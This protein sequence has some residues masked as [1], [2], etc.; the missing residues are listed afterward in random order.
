[1]RRNLLSTVKSGSRRRALSYE[2][3]AQIR[4]DHL[5]PCMTAHFKE[6]LLIE[7]GEGQY[8]YDHT[9]KKYLDLFAGI[10]TVSVG[11][12]HP[13]INKVLFDQAQKLWHTTQIYWY[14]GIHAYAKKLTEKFPEG[15]DQVYF[16]NSGSEANDLALMLARLHTG[17]WNCVALQNSY[18]GASPYARQLTSHGSWKYNLH[19][20]GGVHHLPNPC[21]YSGSFGDDKE[22]YLKQFDDQINLNIGANGLAGFW[23]EPLQGVGGANMYPKGYLKAVYEKVRAAGGV[24]VADEV[25][26]GFGRC[27]THYWGFETHDV[28][29]DIVVMA[30]GIGNGFPMGAIVTTKEISSQMSKALHFNTFGG[31]PLA[32]AIGMEVLD[33]IDEENLQHNSHVVGEYFISG[34]KKLMDKYDFLGDVRGSGLMIGF[35]MSEDRD[36]RKP[37]DTNLVSQIWEDLRK[38]GILLGRG[39]VFGQ[40][41]R[42]KPPMCVTKEDID[43]TIDSFDRAC[44]KVAGNTIHAPPIYAA[45]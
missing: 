7:R 38:D 34:M 23:A 19:G 6:P 31:N 17:R 4:S 20:Q 43:A 35:E 8:L 41:F 2:Q 15:L 1:M 24:C 16:V 27:G 37:F 11:H 45:K 39:G 14:E 28:V 33:V 9:G 3:C 29:P 32:C 42:V 12:C 18:H 13:R 21:V 36:P 44:A 22:A 26:T 40:T 30:K 10:V 5:F 25:Q